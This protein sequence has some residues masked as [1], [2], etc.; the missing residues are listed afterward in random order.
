MNYMAIP[1]VAHNRLHEIYM[2]HAVR[3]GGTRNNVIGFIIVVA[4]DLCC[5]AQVYV[6]VN[7]VIVEWYCNYQYSG[8]PA[9]ISD[10]MLYART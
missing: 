10:I 9:I 8:I 7:E 4:C 1:H 2:F 5:Q 6:C 3:D